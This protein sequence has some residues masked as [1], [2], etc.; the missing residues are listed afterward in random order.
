MFLCLNVPVDDLSAVGRESVETDVYPTAAGLG[1]LLPDELV[2][3]DVGTNPV[4]PPATLLDVAVDAEVCGLSRQV[5]AVR[6]S[7][8]GTVEC[9]AAEA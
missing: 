9:L 6:D 7:A 2:E 3:L 1:V 8:H 4:E 5:L